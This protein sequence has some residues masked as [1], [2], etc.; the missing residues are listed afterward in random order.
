MDAHRAGITGSMDAQRRIK[1]DEEYSRC[2][3]S[4]NKREVDNQ[5]E[6]IHAQKTEILEKMDGQGD[7]INERIDV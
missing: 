6:K 7:K 1:W 4:Q 2:S 3:W 5:N